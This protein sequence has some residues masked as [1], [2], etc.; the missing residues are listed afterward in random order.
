MQREPKNHERKKDQM[1]SF[2]WSLNQCHS[3]MHWHDNDNVSFRDMHSATCQLREMTVM[4]KNIGSQQALIPMW[5]LVP[6]PQFMKVICAHSSLITLALNIMNTSIYS[7]QT[8]NHT[9][10]IMVSIS[11]KDIDCSS[12]FSDILNGKYINISPMTTCLRA[13]MLYTQW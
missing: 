4:N 3:T 11:G 12:I 10:V 6:L 2:K 13:T 1:S 8:T 7:T 9:E 5:A